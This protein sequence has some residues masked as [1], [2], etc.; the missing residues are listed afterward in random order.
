MLETILFALLWF[1]L[2][3]VAAVIGCIAFIAWCERMGAYDDLDKM[4]AEEVR[5]NA[6]DVLKFV[7]IIFPKK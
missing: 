1:V 7:H 5:E 6:K 3:I 2:G 4:E